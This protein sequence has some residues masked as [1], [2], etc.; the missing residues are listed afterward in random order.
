MKTR[1]EPK[2]IMFDYKN[3]IKNNELAHKDALIPLLLALENQKE[4]KWGVIA[5]DKYP[6]ASTRVSNVL[7]ELHLKDPSFCKM[8]SLD[9]VF[10][11]V[12]S[13]GDEPA[14]VVGSKA[15]NTLRR[16][17]GADKDRDEKENKN[18]KKWTLQLAEDVKIKIAI[19]G[20]Q[21][22]VVNAAWSLD[23]GGLISILQALAENGYL[24]SGPSQS[25]GV[26]EFSTDRKMI[27]IKMQDVIVVS[28][29]YQSNNLLGRFGCTMIADVKKTEINEDFYE[30]FLP[31]LYHTLPDSI[32]KSWIT[33]KF[34]N[35]DLFLALQE[36]QMAI[37]TLQQKKDSMEI[38]EK[39]DR[40]IIILDDEEDEEDT[41]TITPEDA[42]AIQ[43]IINHLQKMHEGIIEEAL[44]SP[45]GESAETYLKVIADS[46]NLAQE[47]S[48]N[49]KEP[50]S[51]E[52][53]EQYANKLEEDLRIVSVDDNEEEE[54]PT[55]VVDD[56]EE[57]SS[58]V[59]EEELSP[60][61]KSSNQTQNRENNPVLS[62]KMRLLICGV[63]GAFVG[64]VL[65]GVLGA[66]ATWYLGGSGGLVTGILGA[67][68]GFSVGVAI[69]SSIGFISGAGAGVGG[70]VMYDKYKKHHFFQADEQNDTPVVST[71]PIYK[72]K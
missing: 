67:V 70:K 63:I 32:Q 53:I 25:D 33:N 54:L 26:I 38:K 12:L 15:T 31:K 28:D 56:D 47:W 21:S 44:L 59:D 64:F 16:Y 8:Y 62:N 49:L 61:S 5:S 34:G 65:G 35:S 50:L 46:T 17:L 18:V 4:I 48:K 2:F 14:Q 27:P 1:R 66:V 57:E 43:N 20:D 29:K 24:P 68:K 11:S 58:N 37:T 40:D 51:L 60:L 3:L 30:H 7:S 69:G 19:P 10:D 23:K 41:N 52:R 36:L 6:D 42:Y 45:P 71:K 9:N 72:T 22:T 13:M 39:A 55:Y